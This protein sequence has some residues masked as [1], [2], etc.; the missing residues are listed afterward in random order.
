MPVKKTIKG[1]T[2]DIQKST[3]PGKKLMATYTN[4]STGNKNTIHFGDS[5]AS[6]YKDCSGLL[7]PSQSHGDPKRRANYRSRHAGDNLHKPSPGLLS[8]YCLW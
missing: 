1:T 3:R 6:H 8:Y 2:Y 5:S 4:K 7:P